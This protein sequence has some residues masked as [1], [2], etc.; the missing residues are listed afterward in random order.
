MVCKVA[1]TRGGREQGSP[2]RHTAAVCKSLEGCHTGKTV[3][4]RLQKVEML[5][6]GVGLFLHPSLHSFI[7]L[8]TYPTFSESWSVLG[9]EDQ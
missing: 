8:P 9:V 2:S 4:Q 1:H 7:H 6:V 5:G 3:L